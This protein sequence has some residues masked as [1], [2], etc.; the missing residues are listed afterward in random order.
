MA[1]GDTRLAELRELVAEVLEVE[2]EELTDT[3]DF[4]EEYEADSLRAIEMLARIEKKYKIEIP[5]QELAN[6]QNLKA[7]YAVTAGYA[8]WSE[9]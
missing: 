9:S 8:G 3:G 5:Q 7:V 4:Q 1:D 2:P 6:M